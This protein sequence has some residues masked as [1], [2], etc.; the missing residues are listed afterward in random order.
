MR[1]FLQIFIILI[2]IAVIYSCV[3]KFDL[4]DINVGGNNVNIDGD[5]VFVQLNPVWYGEWDGVS[6]NNPQ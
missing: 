5:T 3:D 4:N 2:L 1:K 6:F